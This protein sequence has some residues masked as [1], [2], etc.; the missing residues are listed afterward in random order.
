[1]PV[2]RILI[3]EDDATFANALGELI[4]RA[5]HEPIV[6]D[7]GD[8]GLVMTRQVAPDAVVLDLRVP[9]IDGW[10]LLDRLKHDPA[11]RAIP[12]CVLTGDPRR[13][14]AMRLG[15]FAFMHKPVSNEVFAAT[16]REI[17]EFLSR[18]KKRVLVADDDESRRH[19]LAAIL[20]GADA[21]IVAI[22]PS[23]IDDAIRG[24][25]F[26]AYVV[27]AADDLALVE[28]I[29]RTASSRGVPILVRR[30][31]TSRAALASLQAVAG[32]GVV[33][34]VATLD[35]VVEEIALS[36][37]RPERAARAARA[38]AH[39]RADPALL[40]KSVLVVD[41]DARNVLALTGLLEPRRM[42][43]VAAR[44]G[45]ESLA[46]LREG[47]PVDLILMDIMMPEMD[48]Y[49]TIRAIRAMEAHRTTPI[50]AVTAKAMKGDREACMAAGASDFV[51][52]PVDSEQLFS[53]MRVLLAD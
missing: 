41:D 15:A 28:R 36:L 39:R 26:D 46:R 19:E 34:P 11:T 1:M 48:G 44:S 14:R 4:R 33:K 6:A 3:I 12:V 49:A 16:L 43:I 24:Q 27:A 52:K 37:H 47:G 10:V 35:A 29:A 13:L 53:V 45:E 21:E 38:G 22:E 8:I 5:G 17:D 30:D 51:A 42:K 25:K 50:V 32:E 2:R 9:G 7:R 31:E 20:E 40:G 23:A 18:E